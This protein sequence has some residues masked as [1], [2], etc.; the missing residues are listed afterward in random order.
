VFP[1][2]CAGGPSLIRF[3]QS[4]GQSHCVTVLHNNAYIA[5]VLGYLPDLVNA[6]MLPEYLGVPPY[7][8]DTVIYDEFAYESAK[9]HCKEEDSNQNE[10]HHQ[11]P[12]YRPFGALGDQLQAH[13]EECQSAQEP[14]HVF[15]CFVS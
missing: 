6:Q 11:H 2:E 5:F 3:H 12:E 4:D 7:G 10:D 14:E 8:Q 15:L 1:E 13:P 9:K